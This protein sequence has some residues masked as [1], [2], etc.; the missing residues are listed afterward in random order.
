VAWDLRRI[1]L[2]PMPLREPLPVLSI[3][4]RRDDAPVTL[5][6]QELVA[7]AYTAGRY[8]DIDYSLPP[9]PPLSAEDAAWAA[10]LVRAAGRG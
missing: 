3:P 4:L 8:D 6:L 7:Q 10:E 2:Y 5:D 1:D 9:T